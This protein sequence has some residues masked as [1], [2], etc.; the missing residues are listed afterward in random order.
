LNQL[1]LIFP[2]AARSVRVIGKPENLFRM[3]LSLG[4]ELILTR[5]ILTPT[6]GGG[7]G[8]EKKN[9]L[10]KKKKKKY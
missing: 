6:G 8:V 3:I 5:T 10:Y 4:P 9:K 7:G 1:N 2:S